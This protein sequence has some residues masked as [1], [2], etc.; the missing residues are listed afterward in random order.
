MEPPTTAGQ[1]KDR[2]RE[3]VINGDK[4]IQG[5]RFIG[6]TLSLVVCFVCVGFF[7]CNQSQMQTMTSMKEKNT[8]MNKCGVAGQKQKQRSMT[9]KHKAESQGKAHISIISLKW[10]LKQ[11][12][13]KAN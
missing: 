13:I 4:D 10:V 11:Q 6:P 1:G 3:Q 9:R 5:C 2:S 8:H 12:M 7:V